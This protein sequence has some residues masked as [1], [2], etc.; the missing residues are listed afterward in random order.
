MENLIA[1]VML[2]LGLPANPPKDVGAWRAR[3]LERCTETSNYV[4]T[5][6][7]TTFKGSLVC[8]CKV[9]KGAKWK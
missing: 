6:Q 5:P 8:R 9:P 7:S 3:L 2:C 1:S 4:Y